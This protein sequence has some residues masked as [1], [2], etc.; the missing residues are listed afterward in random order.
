M[1][2]AMRIHNHLLRRHLRTIGGYEVKTEG[3]AFMVSFQTVTS[4]LLWCFT[5]QLQLLNQDWPK[6]ILEND[7]GRPILDHNSNL[8]SRGLSVRM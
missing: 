7:E 5:I 4:A 3:D 1:Q 8:I 6:E 2:S